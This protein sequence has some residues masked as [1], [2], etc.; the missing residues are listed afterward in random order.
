[1]RWTSNG[2]KMCLF[3]LRREEGRWSQPVAQFFKL[4]IVLLISSRWQGDK[5][6]LT[7]HL[8]LIYDV[9]LRSE[10]G[11]FASRVGPMFAKNLLKCDAMMEESVVELPLIEKIVV[12]WADVFFLLIT[13]LITCHVFLR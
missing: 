7:G 4:S 3:P 8:V 6:R 13:S 1:M 5:N 9:G 2:L 10:G 11:I 12:F